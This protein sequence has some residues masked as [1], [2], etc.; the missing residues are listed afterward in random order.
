MWNAMV[1]NT[2][3]EQKWVQ[4]FSRLFSESEHIYGPKRKKKARTPRQ[5]ASLNHSN[6]SAYA[7]GEA[8][9]L[10]ARLS[11]LSLCVCACAMVC[12][13]VWQGREGKKFISLPGGPGAISR[14]DAEAAAT[15]LATPTNS[16][17][18]GELLSRGT[19]QLIHKVATEHVPTVCVIVRL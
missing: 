8:D 18:P 3:G 4:W 10:N 14:A 15:A 12:V 7:C 9:M 19:V 11:S 2:N 5:P 13:C 17:A 6:V 16:A 1:N